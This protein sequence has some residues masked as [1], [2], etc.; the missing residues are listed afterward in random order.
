MTTHATLRSRRTKAKTVYHVQGLHD[1]NHSPSPLKIQGYHQG[2]FSLL[3]VL[4]AQR[5]LFETQGQYIDALATYHK[6]VAETERLMG[7]EF[8]TVMGIPD[9]QRHGAQP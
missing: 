2:K 5:T 9:P 7:G 6:A 1:R 3:E 4:D 8:A